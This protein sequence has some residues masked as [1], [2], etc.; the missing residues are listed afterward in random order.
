MG[1]RMFGLIKQGVSEP[2]KLKNDDQTEPKF[3]QL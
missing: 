1:K 3:Y 2:A